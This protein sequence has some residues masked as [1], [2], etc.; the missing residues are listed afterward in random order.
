MEWGTGQPKKSAARLSRAQVADGYFAIKEY[1]W[2]SALLKNLDSSPILYPFDVVLKSQY[3]I[4]RVTGGGHHI[5][6]SG[7]AAA[8]KHL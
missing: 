6:S 7:V 2:I 5:L 1:A 8:K 4:G 3:S